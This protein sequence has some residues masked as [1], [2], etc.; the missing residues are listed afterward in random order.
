MLSTLYSVLKELLG[1][2]RQNV[3]CLYRLSECVAVLD[4][5]HSFAHSVT[6]SD[7]GRP[8]TCAT[9]VQPTSHKRVIEDWYIAYHRASGVKCCVGIEFVRAVS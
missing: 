2:I 5:L 7:Y 6:V 1:E 9:I 3:C 8:Y 4:M